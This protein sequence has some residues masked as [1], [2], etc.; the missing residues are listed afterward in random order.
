MLSN[1]EIQSLNNVLATFGWLEGSSDG[2]VTFFINDS[3]HPRSATEKFSADEA[4]DVTTFSA[5]LNQRATEAGL[6]A[7]TMV[8]AV[9]RAYAAAR[10]E[11]QSSAEAVL[12]K[13]V[14]DAAIVAEQEVE[15]LKLDSFPKDVSWKDAAVQQHP[16]MKRR[17]DWDEWYSLVDDRD[18]WSYLASRTTDCEVVAEA[19]NRLE[20]A[21]DLI[22]NFIEVVGD[23]TLDF[24]EYV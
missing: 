24:C 16:A 15:G 23:N 22:G 18:R 14:L 7:L 20:K 2:S 8:A 3:L 13:M 6:S 4:R 10:A 9:V 11:L 19:R 12:N 1:H 5:S 21:L 17:W